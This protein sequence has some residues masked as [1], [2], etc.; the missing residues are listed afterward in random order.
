MTTPRLSGLLR[1]EQ[2]ALGFAASDRDDALRALSALLPLP[3]ED[4]AAALQAVR[5]RE[6][7]QTTGIGQGIAIPHGKSPIGPEI[8]A[9]LGVS[10]DPVDFGAIDGQ[11][12]RIFILVVSR[13]DVTGPHVQALAAVARLLGNRRVR[14]TLL[15]CRRPGEVLDLVREAEGA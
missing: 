11:G 9:V 10:K 8:V 13:P 12:V 2:I 15:A 14:D 5:R 3:D 4:R 7:I 1:P 6:A